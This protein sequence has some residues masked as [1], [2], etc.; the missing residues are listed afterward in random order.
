[1]IYDTDVHNNWA[2][3][4]ELAP[5]LPERWRAHKS[6]GAPVY[7]VGA[8]TY[9]RPGGTPHRIDAQ[10]GGT[11]EPGSDYPLLR[12]QLLDRHG[13]DRALLTFGGN[14]LP[15]LHNSDYAVDLCHAA[16]DWVAE[17][18][19]AR[20]ER[21]FAAA[22]VPT[23]APDEAVKEIE[24]VA[25]MPHFAGILAVANP[26]GRPL[27]SRAYHPIY[28][29]VE[30]TGLT[31]VMHI[32]GE[33]FAADTA[34][35]S[36]TPLA[37]CD[38]FA[39]LNQA[40]I[41][42]MV[43]MVCGG[44]FE[45]FPRLRLLFNE[46]GYTWIPNV[47]WNLDANYR[48][49]KA[50]SPDLRDLPSEYFRRHI[51]VSSQPFDSVAK[52]SVQIELLEAFGGLGDKICFASDYPHYDS[53]EPGQVAARLPAHWRDK[54]MSQNAAAALNWPVSGSQSPRQADVA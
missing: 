24:R 1:M 41:H 42:H 10:P 40:A 36:G 11:R 33:V 14:E 32:G 7:S 3:P 23:N 5:Y 44:V 20:D 30:E 49:L 9:S 52:S 16:N 28:R 25:R 21:L 27:G 31:L 2:S 4:S 53:E 38:E 12:E 15:H 51:W 50:E 43:S 54:V 37:R 35:A 29:A 39:L 34:F 19:L 17:H 22:M 46:V 8:L 6:G 48:V 45:R 18:W 47:F 13:I 26:F